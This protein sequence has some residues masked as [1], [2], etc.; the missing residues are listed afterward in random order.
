MTAD[1]KTPPPAGDAAA[2]PASPAPP[3]ANP[4]LMKPRL[5]GFDYAGAKQAHLKSMA[6]LRGSGAGPMKKAPPRR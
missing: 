6:A 5:T 4:L 2:A 3:D 1:D